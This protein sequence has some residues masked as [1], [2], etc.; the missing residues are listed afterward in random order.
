MSSPIQAPVWPT[1]PPPKKTPIGLVIIVAILASSLIVTLSAIV[2]YYAT[3]DI[4][5]GK[6][7]QEAD[8]PPASTS[9]AVADPDQSN[10]PSPRS[11]PTNQERLL[12]TTQGA[13][14]SGNSVGQ[15]DLNMT[16]RYVEAVIV[17]ADKV[18]SAWMKGLGYPEPYVQY[19]IIQPGSDLNAPKCPALDP[20]TKQETTHYDSKFPNAFYCGAQSNGVDNGI[21]ILP[22]ESIARMWTGDILG[23]P[24][25][26]PAKVGDFAAASVVA[27]EFGHHVA[28]EL[29]EDIPGTQPPQGKNAELLADCFSGV[30]TTALYK[31]G[32]LEEGDIDEAL[33]ALHAV[34]DKSPNGRFPHGTAEERENA[35]RIGIYGLQTDPRGGVPANCIKVYWPGFGGPR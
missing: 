7:Q 35:F 24:V 21:I 16:T 18:W 5:K 31:D 32:N 9:T 25:S 12:P 34:G 23:T 26:D 1:P 30:W 14:D 13:W 10:Q 6:G 20:R 4:G 17:N 15:P 33:N 8:P 11:R 19:Y 27:H 2:V 3:G 28:D 22:I 29:A